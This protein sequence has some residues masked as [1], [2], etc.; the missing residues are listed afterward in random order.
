MK[1]VKQ[2]EFTTNVVREYSFTPVPEQ[3]GLL[4]STMELFTDDEPKADNGYGS[5]E[6]IVF[7]GEDEI[8]VEHIG[9]WWSGKKL[10]DYD[11]V[12]SLPMEA[13]KLIRSYGITVSKDFL[14]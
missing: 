13:I 7:D 2:I 14:P 9:L 12:F 5:I 8:E 6:W 11:G 4:K 3:L 1:S 10:T